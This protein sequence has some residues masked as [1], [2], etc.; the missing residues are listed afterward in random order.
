MA[1]LTE[2][3][4]CVLRHRCPTPKA[5]DP[6][7]EASELIGRLLAP[8]T[9]ESFLSS[10]WAEKVLLV[11]GPPKRLG[12]IIE[13]LSQLNLEDMLQETPSEQVHAWLKSP[14]ET[15][16]QSVPLEP[17]AA[18][19]LQRCGQAAL[20]FRAPEALEDLLVPGICTGLRAAFAG[21]YPGDGR[22]R[23][24]I[25]TFV[26][27]RGHVTGWHTDFQHNFTFQLRGSKR[28]RFKQG[29]VK[30][31]D[32]ESISINVSISCASWADLVSDAIRQSLWSSSRL[33]APIV[34][35]QD[36]VEAK[37][38]VE[39]RLRE[40][41]KH[42]NALRA[43]DLLSPVMLEPRLPS[44]IDIKRSRLGHELPITQQMSFRFSH[45]SAL[46][47]LPD[48]IQS[49]SEEAQRHERGR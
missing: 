16:L 32:T 21:I 2:H 26:A 3:L 33:R 30:N 11:E 10:C 39:D 27:Q 35:L 9:V 12:P 20:Y 41:K 47:Q 45:L 13:Q 15:A 14:T 38:M 18:L 31:N 29:P 25:E 22:P 1:G 28:W 42:I 19:A 24:E 6:A 17:A 43:E 40:A 23:G 37:R 46:V 7:L 34:G 5:I 44:R 49:E 48:E 4:G 36:F 8:L